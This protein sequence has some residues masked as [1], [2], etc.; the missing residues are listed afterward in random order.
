MRLNR[1]YSVQRQTILLVNGGGGG[2]GGGASKGNLRCE[3]VKYSVS[4]AK[5]ITPKGEVV[6]H[7]NW[8][9]C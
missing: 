6:E 3:W 7:I 2:G 4:R 9:L 8:L 5:N 1:V